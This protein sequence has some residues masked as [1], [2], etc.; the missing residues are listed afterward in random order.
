MR[1]TSTSASSTTSSA[2]T[3]RSARPMSGGWTVTLFE[4]VPGGVGQAERLFALGGDLLAA[5]RALVEACG[6]AEGCPSCVGPILEVGPQGKQHT[7]RLLKD[8]RVPA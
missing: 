5:A 7:L 1:S 8:A 2:S 3:G 4:R 6:C